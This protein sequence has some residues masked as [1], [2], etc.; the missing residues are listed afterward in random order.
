M[1]S[2]RQI[3]LEIEA[4]LAL[5][6]ADG[7]NAS[8]SLA[9]SYAELCRGANGRL[10]RCAD[11]V[12]RGLRSEA[13]HTAELEPDLLTL[14]ADLDFE[15]VETWDAFCAREQ[16]DRAP[17]LLV[18]V[19]RE[20]NEAYVT[21]QPLRGLLR[22]LRVQNLARAP[23][24]DRL[25]VLRRLAAVDPETVAW[26]EDVEA[27]EHARLREARAETD[28]FLQGGKLES[29]GRLLADLT[30][31]PWRI[32]VP[33]DLVARVR[34]AIRQVE[35]ARAHAELHA[36]LP[37][38]HDAHSAMSYDRASELLTRWRAIAQ[39]AGVDVPEELE[40]QV[41]PVADWAAAEAGFREAQRAVTDACARVRA[42]LDEAGPARELE[43]HHRE[44]SS[45]DQP[46]PADLERDYQAEI[47][48]RQVSA[49]RRYRLL[50][51]GAACL[52]L[53]LAAGV[54]VALYYGRLSERV[55]TWRH[56]I[57]RATEEAR[58]DEAQRL[59][60]TLG[61]QEPDL[62]VR[63]PLV[64][65][66]SI[67]DRAVAAEAERKREFRS[68]MD[69]AEGAGLDRPDLVAIEAAKKVARTPEEKDEVRAFEGRLRQAAKD[70][71]AEIDLA[72]T[73]RL[74]EETARVG[75][76]DAA[77]LDS[78]PAGFGKALASCE[79]AV[80]TLKLAPSMSPEVL[81]ATLPL[82]ARVRSLRAAYEREANKREGWDRE[83]EAIARL[84][85]KAGS[86]TDYAQALLGFATTFPDS[87]RTPGFRAAAE[88][89][90]AWSA[91]EAW[92]EILRSWGG[93]LFPR[94]A[95]DCADRIRTVDAYLKSHAGSP[96]A[97]ALA[98]YRIY[99]DRALLAMP[100]DNP[101]RANLRT[102]LKAPLLQLNVVAT[103]DG[104]T[105]YVQ[106]DGDFVENNDQVSFKAVLSDDLAEPPKTIH[107]PAAEVAGRPQ[108][109]AQT[110]LA[111]ELL[112]RLNQLRP[113]E[114]E[115]SWFD[116]AQVLRD[117]K[118]VD[119][120]L[121]AFLLSKLLGDLK[122][123]GFGVEAEV[124][125]MF[126]TLSVDEDERIYWMDPDDPKAKHE[127]QR[128]DTALAQLTP[129]AQLRAV[130]ASKRR[131]LA[132]PLAF[133]CEGRG[134]IL[135]D[136]EG[137]RVMASRRALV[138]GRKAVI[139]AGTAAGGTAWRLRAIGTVRDGAV[140][141]EEDMSGVLEG[142]L[143]FLCDP[144]RE[145]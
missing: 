11:Y 31:Q 66:K 140:S 118:E 16:L 109:G 93:N 145:R 80:A 63:A 101:I 61:Q 103:R 120:Y 15:R 84:E 121:R 46:I 123:H 96:F 8:R 104:R 5:G 33:A 68:L 57:A 50:V 37:E 40:A 64:E 36:L 67:L 106:G 69:A 138:D 70:A 25:Q 91:I 124:D 82:E 112:T 2:P 18:D 133:D 59:W 105:Y 100:D 60:E 88:Q 115:T 141:I 144:P 87:P 22:Q 72:F 51:A 77:W 27:F 6:D 86:A 65:A 97:S 44:A 127:R 98:P 108:M 4:F 41:R 75:K 143:V 24:R 52:V 1:P 125:E 131:E 32:A 92:G 107:L 62:A 23:L 90:P 49:R 71:Q 89:A 102:Y 117:R 74:E 83:R 137:W 54:A 129:P 34:A 17:R 114:W 26:P 19:A 42:A 39:S 95:V 20:L 135:R 126:R 85:E 43:R 73:A 38:L 128:L 111:R 47:Q 21:E 81:A 113:A 56:R 53:A 58:L 94:T 29:L 79:A 122:Q 48:R 139:V 132:E 110:I 136:G 28:A 142:S 134:V 130:V 119:A 116:V 3:V 9:A 45:F 30:E 99:L 14:V 7:E 78:D 55:E 35:T 12:R 76:L 13:I 10:R